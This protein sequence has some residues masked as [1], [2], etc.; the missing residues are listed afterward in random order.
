MKE[1][2]LTIVKQH[3]RYIIHAIIKQLP[4]ARIC[5]RLSLC[6]SNEY[7]IETENAMNQIMIK[8]QTTPQ[9]FLCETIATKLNIMLNENSTITEIEQAVHTVCN[10]VAKK[11]VIK[12]NELLGNYAEIIISLLRSVPPKELCASLN[13]CRKSMISDTKFHDIL[14]CG[15]CNAAVNT[16]TT[17]YSFNGPKD[18][19]TL[20]TITCNLLPL[21]YKEQVT[22]K[23]HFENKK[24]L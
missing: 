12:C 5:H 18:K 20:E 23:L 3:Q 15:V 24:K 8:Y 14:E 17:I 1:K 9:C 7:D 11:N 10:V 4:P 13:F 22:G 6:P 19:D 2:C 16:L 21:K